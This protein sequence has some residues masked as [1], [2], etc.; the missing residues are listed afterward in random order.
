MKRKQ[1]ILVV[2]L[3]FALVIELCGGFFL[4]SAYAS[5][6]KDTDSKKTT[7]EKVSVQKEDEEKIPKITK[8]TATK[9]SVKLYIED[10]DSKNPKYIYKRTKKGAFK[11]IAKLSSKADS[12]LDTKV[13]T[14]T[15]YYYQ[16]KNED[17]LFSKG[18]NIMGITPV[19]ITAPKIISIKKFNTP[20]GNNVKLEWDAKKG[21]IYRISRKLGDGEWHVLG[22]RV[23]SSS[24][25]SYV[26]KNV[27]NKKYKYTCRYVRKIDKE[28][29]KYGDFDKSG[30]EIF[31][32]KPKV[33]AKCG[34]M[35]ANLE[36]TPIPGADEYRVYRKIGLDG[37]YR[38]IKK[39]T[40]TSFEDFYKKTSRTDD[41]KAYLAAYYFVDPSVNPFVYTVRAIKNNNG[42]LS[43]S[44]LENN[45]DFHREPV[46]I[47]S[48]DKPS[49]TQVKIEWGTV[50]N[51][52][53][54]LIY[55]GNKL[56]NG[57]IQWRKVKEVP[58]SKNIRLKTT[59]NV[60]KEE[61]WFTIKT[62]YNCD[63]NVFIVKGDE[64]ITV[65]KRKYEDNNVLFIGD[66]I[67][68]GSPYK[69]LQ[70]K[71]VFSYPWRVRELTGCKIYNPSIPGA[72][73]ACR[74][75]NDRD[76]MV[77]QVAKQ[78]Y[79]GKTPYA[80]DKNLDF[81]DGGFNDQK[82]EDFDVVVMA[83]GTNDYSD[84]IPFGD[85]NSMN[86]SEFNGAV[87]QIMAWIKEGSDA[88]VEAGKEPIKIVFEE[89]FY[90]DR[91]KHFKELTN[92]FVT[93]NDIGLTLT[94]YQ[95]NINQLVAKYK[96]EGFEIYEFDTTEFVNQNTCP[97]A[98]SDN[99]HMSRFTYGKV[100]N[101]LA[102]FL[103]QNEIIKEKRDE[104]AEER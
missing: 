75:E 68:Y 17:D 38:L 79:E 84:N 16:V 54:Y 47:I 46:S 36:W 77:T 8:I 62:K 25:G 21:A 24:I 71:N 1:S 10:F 48:V 73:Y 91:T 92:R 15:T 39:T 4:E 104:K 76:R 55:A 102:D 56:E 22:D 35:K 65:E 2:I 89:L 96:N 31:N 93:K 26:D 59:A 70:T 23:A 66:S 18:G 19:V 30:I 57:N 32:G 90:S 53:S 78:I 29:I 80:K 72:T 45:G 12:Y 64:G 9:N 50:M 67:T 41:E 27:G 51:A 49:E 13:K 40:E 94:D 5:K 63:G 86:I 69:T 103:I 3:I 95:N 28:H 82:Y 100:G 99:L 44:D 81:M 101:R 33:T 74:E 43:Y 37:E 97:Y 85:L 88:R 52:E 20:K 11:K 98:T 61:Q 34:N 14:N 87:N 7:S 58:N 60:N 83:C 42:K 6:G